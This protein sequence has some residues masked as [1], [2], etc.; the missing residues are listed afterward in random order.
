MQDTEIIFELLTEPFGKK[1]TWAT[2]DIF[3]L[4]HVKNACKKASAMLVSVGIH[5]LKSK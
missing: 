4:A 5:A 2:T 3:R 1:A